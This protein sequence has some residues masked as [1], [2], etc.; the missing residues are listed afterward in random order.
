M[1]GHVCDGFVN[2]LKPLVTACFRRMS[3]NR[4]ARIHQALKTIDDL[5]IDF[6]YL[7]GF[8]FVHVETLGAISFTSGK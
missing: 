7:D 4:Y 5:A 3:G 1:M 8:Q 6:T 2:R